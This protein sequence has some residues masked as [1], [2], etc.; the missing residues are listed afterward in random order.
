MRAPLQVK[1]EDDIMD[2]GH[3]MA[4]WGW[5]TLP[6][7]SSYNSLWGARACV[8]LLLVAL[9][10]QDHKGATLKRAPTT[11]HDS[12]SSL[13]VQTTLRWVIDAALGAV[14]REEGPLPPCIEPAQAGFW[15]IFRV[16]ASSAEARRDIFD[17]PWGGQ[18]D[19]IFTIS[20]QG[21]RSTPAWAG[22]MQGGK[23]GRAV[24]LV[25]LL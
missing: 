13:P 22:L 12:I 6:S 1:R 23:G 10:P 8:Y 17:P 25:V 2:W 14:I 11:L 18:N 19:R 5:T 4:C 15:A 16:G 24:A 20:L 7:A 9:F 3:N 21:R